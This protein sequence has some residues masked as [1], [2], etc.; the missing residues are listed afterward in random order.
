MFRKLDTR[1]TL[2]KQTETNWEHD[3]GNVTL[4]VFHRPDLDGWCHG[5]FAARRLGRQSYV[6]D[7]VGGQVLE[8]I[9]IPRR[10]DG[11]HDVLTIVRVVVIELVTFYAVLRCLRRVPSQLDSVRGY[12]FS[13]QIRRL[14][15]YW[16]E[17]KSKVV[18]CIQMGFNKDKFA[19]IRTRGGS[20]NLFWGG[21]N[22]GPQSKVEAKPESR[23]RSARVSRAKPES[24]AR[25]A[26]ELRAKPEPR[27]KPDNIAGGG[28]WGGGSVSP[29]PYNIWYII[30]EI[31]HFGAYMIAYIYDM[32]I[33]IWYIYITG[34]DKSSK[35]LFDV[36]DLLNFVGV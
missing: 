26:R 8:E 14:S 21:P 19:N 12:R 24:R 16:W 28:V 1:M 23:A 33:Y 27:A 35:Q 3:I 9:R 2:L 18:E 36:T 11:E 34:H 17:R 15:R 5:S 13:L 20:R 22:Q 7:R 4:T 30:L 29:S 31:I 10:F 6:V 32:T 25:S